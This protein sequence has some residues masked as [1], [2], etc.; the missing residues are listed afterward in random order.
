LV[1]FINREFVH[2]SSYGDYELLVRR[3]H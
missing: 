3:D 2:D 1:D